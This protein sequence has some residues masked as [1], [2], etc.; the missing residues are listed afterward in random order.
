[1]PAGPTIHG[2]A[3]LVGPRAVLMRGPAGSGKSR[4]ALA[5][6]DSA[7]TQLL[8]FARL[9]ADDR[10]HVEAVHGRL[11]ARSAEAI[12]GIL[13]V[14]GLGLRQ[15][16]YEPMAVIGLVVDLSAGSERLP[17]AAERSVTIEGVTLPRIGIGSDFPPLPLVLAALRT[18]ESSPS[19][20]TYPGVA[21]TQQSG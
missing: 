5:L 14:R 19:R 12:C 4:L 20:L 16:P 2:T 21:A 8:P 18:V 7:I 17:Q 6:I 10:V 13:E 11:L 9:V 15:V 1:M 3:V